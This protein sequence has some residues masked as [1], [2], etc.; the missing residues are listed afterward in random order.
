MEYLFL[1]ALAL[2]QIALFTMMVLNKGIHVTVNVGFKG[3]QGPMGDRGDTGDTGPIGFEGGTKIE[4][5]TPTTVDTQYDE[6]GEL[7]EKPE[8][9][10]RDIAQNIQAIMLGQEVDDVRK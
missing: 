9:F 2:M 8:D 6:N 4:Y 1:I 10:L 3:P 7:K 5:I